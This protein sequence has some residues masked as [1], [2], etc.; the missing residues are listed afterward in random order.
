[1]GCY[2]VDEFSRCYLDYW[3]SHLFLVYCEFFFFL[4]ATRCWNFVKSFCVSIKVIMILPFQS[5]W[6]FFVV[7]AVWAFSSYGKCGLLSNCSVGFSFRW[8]LLLPSMVSSVQAS[9]V[10]AHG[11][12]C[13]VACGV[14]VPGPRIEA[15]SLAL[16][17]GSLVPRAPGKSPFSVC[18]YHKLH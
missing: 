4:V 15:M 16:A 14:L 3:S 2:F 18:W 13:P 11:L 17:D 1:M 8:L 12:S 7:V 9:I 5:V 10:A 6:V